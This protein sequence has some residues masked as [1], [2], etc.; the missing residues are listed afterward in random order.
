MFM[1][2]YPGADGSFVPVAS[3]ASPIALQKGESAYLIG[4]LAAGST[5]LPVNEGNVAFEPASVDAAEPSLAVCL[6]AGAESMPPPMVC[7][8]VR[9]NGAPGAGE[10]IAIQEADTDADGYY[11]TPSNANYTINAFNANNAARV[12]LSPTGGKFLRLLRT[13]GANAVGCIAKVTRLA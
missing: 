10:I 3:N 2:D 7:V 8:E 5:Q 12:D 13:K 4:L 11:I 9:F 6:Q 1:P